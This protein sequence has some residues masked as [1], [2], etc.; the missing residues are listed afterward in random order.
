VVNPQA[1]GGSRV[2]ALTLQPHVVEFLDVVM[3]DGSIEF[4]LEE[5]HLPVDSPLVG[6]SIQEANIRDATG[7]MVMGLRELDGTFLANPGPEIVLSAGQVL[8]GIG[9]PSQLTSLKSAAGVSGD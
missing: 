1:I 8:I 5:V 3:H 9:T 7:A 6:R 4:R 2:A